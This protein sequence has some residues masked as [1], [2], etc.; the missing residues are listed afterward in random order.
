MNKG[1]TTPSKERAADFPALRAAPNSVAYGASLISGPESA[2]NT[3]RNAEIGWENREK[4][5]TPLFA[6]RGVSSNWNRG[7]N[8]PDMCVRARATISNMDGAGYARV[9]GFNHPASATPAWWCDGGRD[10]TLAQP[11][12]PGIIIGQDGTWAVFSARMFTLW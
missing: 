12:T 4:A 2:C 7:G 6:A 10:R 1:K 3:Q 5:K 8:R 9:V 11:A